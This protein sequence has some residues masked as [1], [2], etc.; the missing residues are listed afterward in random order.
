MADWGKLLAGTLLQSAGTA[1]ESYFNENSRKARLEEAQARED[2]KWLRDKMSQFDLQQMQQEQKMLEQEGQFHQKQITDRF[3][4]EQALAENE[5]ARWDKMNQYALD[6]YSKQYGGKGSTGPTFNIGTNGEITA[7]NTADKFKVSNDPNYIQ[8][9][10]VDKRFSSRKEDDPSSTTKVLRDAGIYDDE[11]K[12]LVPNY[13]DQLKENNSWGGL[14]FTSKFN[15]GPFWD[16][17]G[18]RMGNQLKNIAQHKVNTGDFQHVGQ[19]YDEIKDRKDIL[20]HAPWV[21]EA[22][23]DYQM[24]VAGQEKDKQWAGKG[25]QSLSGKNVSGASSTRPDF[26]EFRKKFLQQVY[27]MQPDQIREYVPNLPFNMEAG[28]KQPQQMNYGIGNPSQNEKDIAGGLLT[29][30]MSNPAMF[31]GF[32]LNANN[33]SD[34]RDINN[35][36]TRTPQL[37]PKNAATFKNLFGIE[38]KKGYVPYDS[39]Y[40]HREDPLP[41]LNKLFGIND[42]DQKNMSYAEK[43]AYDRDP[44][45]Q[46]M[47]AEE[48]GNSAIQKIKENDPELTSLIEQVIFT[49][50]NPKDVAS[51][52]SKIKDRTQLM[53]FLK[54]ELGGILE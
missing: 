43:K 35:A 25:K 38:D 47:H 21:E 50:N 19:I 33:N 7:S 3:N 13:L 49:S 30:D 27:G 24:M 41:E 6:A 34:P 32:N 29:T 10:G 9:F 48:G 12:H 20:K 16:S 31:N 45:I 1:G 26:V 17:T 53:A 4:Y 8:K 14:P 52:I 23:K 22:Y 5:Q 36:T 40:T 18:E 39:G 44:Q 11:T 54:G 46:A 51:Q 37:D 15:T 42:D 28:L 2:Q